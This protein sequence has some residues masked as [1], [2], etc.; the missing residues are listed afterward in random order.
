MRGELETEQNSNILTPTLM[1]ITA[2]LSRSP[3]LLNCGPGGPATLRYGPPSSIFSPTDW[4]S[5]LQLLN[6]GSWG[7]PLLGAGSLYSILSPTDSSFLCTE[8]YYCFTSTQFNMSTVKV[9]PLIPPTGCICYLHR[10]IS[11]FD[12][13]AGVSI[14]QHSV[15]VTFD[16]IFSLSLSLSLSL[17]YTHTCIHK[18]F[19]LPSPSL[20]LSLTHSH[21]HPRCVSFSRH[22]ILFSHLPYLSLSTLF[23]YP[24]SIS[25]TYTH[26]RTLCASL[27]TESFLLLPFSIAHSSLNLS[28]YLSIKGFF[29]S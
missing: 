9:S 26:I 3:G 4:G 18:L 20:H 8:L 19:F 12:G 6:R 25:H 22:N 16:I 5:E 23:S 10:C 28:I 7:A 27:L 1:A 14:Q 21:T 29:K 17:S 2:F 13:S 15:W 24:Y 11:Y